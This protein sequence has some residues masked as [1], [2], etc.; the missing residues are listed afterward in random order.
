METVFLVTAV[1]GVPTDIYWVEAMGAGKYPATQRMAPRMK[2]CLAP[3][4]NSAETEKPSSKL[5]CLM[6]SCS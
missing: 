6:Y 1:G 5:R 2:N 3:N 4:L